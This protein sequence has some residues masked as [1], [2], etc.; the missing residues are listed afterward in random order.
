MKEVDEHVFEMST[1]SFQ[2]FNK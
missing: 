1:I 2:Y